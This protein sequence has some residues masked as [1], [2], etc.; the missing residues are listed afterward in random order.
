MLRRHRVEFVIS[1]VLGVAVAIGVT[2]LQAERSLDAAAHDHAEH[3]FWPAYVAKANDWLFN[4]PI[5]DPHHLQML[6]AKDL[7]RYQEMRKAW[8]DFDEEMKRAGY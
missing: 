7:K 5:S 2:R 3:V 1:L 4:H 8:H 6:D